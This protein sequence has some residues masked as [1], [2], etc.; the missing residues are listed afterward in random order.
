MRE[1]KFRGIPTFGKEFV[2]G[3][4]ISEKSES[5]KLKYYIFEKSKDGYN[6]SKY[7]IKKETIGQL[8]GLKDENGKEVYIGDMVKDD[9]GRYWEITM[10]DLEGLVFLNDNRREATT[11]HC[12]GDCKVKGS[13]YE[14]P[15]LLKLT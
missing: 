10:R 8:T 4:L 12:V 15:N 13:I 1:I 7:E 6:L 5:G 11:D 2:F 9:E 14:N 3:D